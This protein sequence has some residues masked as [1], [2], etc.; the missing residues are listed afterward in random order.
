[1]ASSDDPLASILRGGSSSASEHAVSNTGT[2]GAKGSHRRPHPSG[3][4]NR[5]SSAV[6]Q[7][8]ALNAILKDILGDPPQGNGHPEQPPGKDFFFV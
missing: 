7:D 2:H 4:V 5:S 3:S 8:H 6:Q 1:M